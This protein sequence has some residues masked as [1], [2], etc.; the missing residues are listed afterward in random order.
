M[1][2]YR[3]NKKTC[4]KKIF[5]VLAVLFIGI[6]LAGCTSQPAAPV[7]TPAP[8]AVPTAMPT[9]VPTAVPTAMP[10]TAATPNVTVTPTPTPTPVPTYT[11]TFTQSM[12]ILPSA[13]AYIKAGTMVIWA[14]QDSLKPHG[15]QA[16]G[17][18]TGQYFGT[19]DIKSIPYGKTFSV[20]F[21]KAGSYDYKTV[22]QPTVTGK[23]VVT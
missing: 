8:T 6:L 11:I 7:A 14:N 9:A 13:T 22:F 20:T 5:V 10:T 1:L 3:D 4:M 18:T 23:I 17:T 12:T 15:V 21:T 2:I 19:S 16:I